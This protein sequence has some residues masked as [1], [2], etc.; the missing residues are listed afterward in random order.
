MISLVNLVTEILSSLTLIGD[1]LLIFLVYKILTKKDIKNNFLNKNGL[2]FAF[3]VALIATCGS[4]FFSEIAGYIPC[5]LCW[6]QRIFMYP[7]PI[8]LGMA[9][10]KKDNKISHYIIPLG[11]FGG[12]ISIY[13]YSTQILKNSAIC[14]AES[15]TCAS[16]I[17]ISYGYITIPIMALT[18]FALIIILTYFTN[19]SERRS[20]NE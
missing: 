14:S 5:K 10:L 4:L 13:H 11:I 19:R 20:K 1:V 16:R 15:S 6:Y 9:L 8:L 18:A 12:I 2:L 17:F 7:L 3:I